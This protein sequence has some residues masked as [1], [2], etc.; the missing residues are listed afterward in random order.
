MDGKK[1][2][3]YCFIKNLLYELK[4]VAIFFYLSII[5]YFKKVQLRRKSL[6]ALK[7]MSDEQLKDIGLT[8]DDID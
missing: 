4:T 5:N 3:K 1:I 2:K 7:K 6:L 8:R